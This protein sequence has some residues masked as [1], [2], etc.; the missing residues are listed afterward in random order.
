MEDLLAGAVNPDSCAQ[1]QQAAGIGGGDNRGASGLGVVHFFGEQLQRC[2]GLRNVVDSSGAAADFRVG[3][4][5]KIKFGYG[6]QKSARSFADFLSV[7]K[8]A[9]I[10][11]GDAEGKRFEFGGE[12]EG[13]EEFGDVANFSREGARLGKL[14]FFGQKEMMVFLERGATAGRVGDDGVEIFAEEDGKIFLCEFAGGVANASVRGEG[15]AT[16]L[17]FGDDDF[18]AVGGEDADG[19]FIELRERDVGD[20]AGEESHACAAR[21]DGGVAPTIAAVEKMIVDA[22]EKTFAVGEAEQFQDANGAGDGLQ[23]GALI[24]TKNP[25][26]VGDDVGIGEQLVEDEVADDAGEPGAL[27]LEIDARTG[28]F[29]EFAVLDAGWAGGFAG[30]AVETFV[31]VVDEGVGDG[32]VF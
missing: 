29:D 31:D 2:F 1:L 22:R 9:G 19:G 12:A 27:V 10:L 16:E 5:H 7:E 30:A 24:E 23:A 13:D 15:A 4:F 17:S 32:L 25:R 14:R 28:V 21:A 26:E 11:V 3:Q 8:M 20:A 6:A 18:A